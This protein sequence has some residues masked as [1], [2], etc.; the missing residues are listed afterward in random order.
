[1]ALTL[2]LIGD[3][4][5][6]L[7]FLAYVKREEEMEREEREDGCVEVEE[8]EWRVVR[9]REGGGSLE[10]GEVKRREGEERGVAIEG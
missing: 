4:E 6:R 1:M 9:D 8:R 5:R 10:V 3:R 7:G 2:T